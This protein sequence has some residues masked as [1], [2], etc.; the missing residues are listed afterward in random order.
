MKAALFYGGHDIRVGVVPD[1]VPGPGEVVV[2]VKAA[3]IC[4]S[5]M[6]GYRNPGRSRA[7]GYPYTSGHELAGEIAA[8]GAGVEGLL[9]GQRVGVE[10][11]HLTGCGKCRYCLRG[12]YHICPTRGMLNG[13]RVHSTGFAEYSLEPADK[14]FP[15]PDTMRIEEAAI[16]DVYACAVHA[17]RLVPV[18]PIHTVVVQGAGPI[19]LTALE[20]FKLGGAK[21][22]IVCGTSAHSLALATRLGADAVINSTAEDPA[23]AVLALTGGHGADVVIEAVGGSAPTLPIAINM[24]ARGGSVLV[25]GMFSQPQTIDTAELMRKEV[26]LLSSNSYALWEGVP[27]FVVALDLLA[28]GKIK[29]GEYIT[30]TFPLDQVAEGFAV[31]DSKRASGAIKVV[32]LP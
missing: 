28:A 20:L 3:G 8:L 9:I 6:H 7:S 23:A 11:R 25:I 1:P 29:P 18:N 30:H 2:R 22:V 19:G 12:D 5:D 24:A 10:P 27:E 26:R 16:L 32:L 31:A 17:L 4:G 21:R 13:Q 14:V 15:L